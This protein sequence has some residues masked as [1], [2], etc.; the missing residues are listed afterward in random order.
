MKSRDGRKTLYGARV[1]EGT[2]LTDTI[3]FYD[4]E[5]KTSNPV[6]VRFRDKVKPGQFS[7]LDVLSINKS[8]TIVYTWAEDIPDSLI[9]EE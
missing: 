1:P 5:T 9:T 4:K 3:E 6:F 8:R 7:E 2:E